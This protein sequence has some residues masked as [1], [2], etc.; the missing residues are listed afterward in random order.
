MVRD[1][2]NA[3]VPLNIL[4]RGLQWD[5]NSSLHYAAAY[6]TDHSGA[7]EKLESPPLSL[8]RPFP[9]VLNHGQGPEHLRWHVQLH[10]LDAFP[11]PVPLVAG[12]PQLSAGSQKAAPRGVAPS[13][14]WGMDTHVG[15]IPG[16]QW[17]NH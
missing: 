16:C 5:P 4:K 15:K 1:L 13:S 17:C 6:I 9:K 14:C 12:T 11:T 10:M 8:T 3:F 7:G 2:H